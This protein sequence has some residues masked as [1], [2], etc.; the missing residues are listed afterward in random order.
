VALFEEYRPRIHDG[1]RSPAPSDLVIRPASPAD[2]EGLAELQAAREGGRVPEHASQ[3]GASMDAN[4]ATGQGI[5]LVAAI[6]GSVVGL[7]KVTHFTPPPV[8][9]RNVAPK[10]WYLSGLIVAAEYRRRGIGRRMIR[11][12]LDWI[13]RYERWAYYFANVRNLVS[14]DL[15]REFGFVELTRD[16]VYPGVTFEGGEGIIFRAEISLQE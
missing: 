8:A 12:R 6:A 10:G 13:A 14:M 16:F 15:H 7:G 11:S 9:P 4:T 2:V 1:E 5:I 3:L